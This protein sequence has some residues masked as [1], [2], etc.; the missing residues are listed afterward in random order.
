M[1]P[2][3][4]I[5]DFTSS[6]NGCDWL[7]S[8]ILGDTPQKLSDSDGYK[9]NIVT[10][11]YRATVQIDTHSSEKVL[12]D[13]L[14]TLDWEDSEAVIFN[15]V[16]T[17]LCLGQSEKL[18]SKIKEFCPAVCLYVVPTASDDVNTDLEASRTDILDW[19]LT[20]QF[21][22]VQCDDADQ[23]EEDEFDERE[24]KERILSALKAHTWSNLELGDE[25]GETCA[26]S[27]TAVNAQEDS[28]SESLNQMNFSSLQGDDDEE[29]NFEDLFSQFHKMKEMSKTL[30]ESERKAYAEKVA[31]AFYKSIGG[32]SGDE[33]ED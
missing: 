6:S 16:N 11:Y 10:K 13:I 17:K 8:L 32:D 4:K 14:D 25:P 18:W 20:N 15:C 7:L 12:S 1:L 24:G 33:S 3:C 26:D 5:I 21:E 30:P 29:I 27:T 2:K 31:L 22:L 23:D 9:W 19:C 28:I